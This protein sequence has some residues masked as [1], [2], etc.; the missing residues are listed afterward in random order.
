[1]RLTNFLVRLILSV[2]MLAIFAPTSLG[3]NPANVAILWLT[4]FC[5]TGDNGGAEAALAQAGESAAPILIQAA[6]VGPSA[7]YVAGLIQQYGNEYDI[8]TAFILTYGPEIGMSTSDVEA[9]T[10]IT[11]DQYISDQVSRAVFSYQVKAL[12]GLGIIGGQA[13]LQVLQSIANNNSSPLQPI[14]QQVLSKFAAPTTMAAN[15]T[16]KTGPSNARVWTLTFTNNGPGTA[17][18]VQVN[19][20][21]LT[22]T[23]GAACTPAV[24]FPETF[25][26]PVGNIIPASTG[27]TSITIDFTGCPA[28]ARFTANISFSANSGI[29]TGTVIR[30]NQ[31][32]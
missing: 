23:F 28:N 26:F 4:R 8:T 16:A 9:E 7:D 20:L 17:M 25:P 14:A 10:A 5:D 21:N 1:M 6:Q 30:Y 18:N 12:V 15:I 3:Q 19:S 2:T 27:S 11:R 29:V 31:F 22:Q 24:T 32:E 13:A